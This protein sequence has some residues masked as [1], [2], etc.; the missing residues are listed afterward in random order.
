PAEEIPV[1]ARDGPSAAGEDP[2]PQKGRLQ[3]PDPF[4]AAPRAARLRARRALRE[5]PPGAR[6]LQSRIRAAAHPRARRAQGRLQPQPV[7]PPDLRAV[8]RGVRTRCGGRAC[9]ARGDTAGMSVTL[10]RDATRGHAAP[11]PFARGENLSS[12]LLQA[13]MCLCALILL[14]PVLLIV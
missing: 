1:E 8:A 10:R 4:V 14:S 2:E 5:A 9:A 7:G 3:R 13:F 6:L 11:L 12:R